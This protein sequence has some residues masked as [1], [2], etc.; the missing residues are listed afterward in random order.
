MDRRALLAWLPALALPGLVG[1]AG[2][3]RLDKARSFKSIDITGNPEFGHDFSLHDHD[4]RPR[5]LSDYRGKVVTL[6]FGYLHC[7][8][9]CPTHLAREAAVL[10]ALG[11][12]DAARVQTL[13]VSV[14][15]ARDTPEKIKAYVTVFHPSFIG[16]TGTEQE[17]AQAARTFK[18]SYSKVPMPDSSLGYAIDH[19]TLTL[20][21]DP[22]GRLRLAVRHEQSATD[23]ATDL[24]R[25]LDGA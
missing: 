15:P 11:P 2:C 3:E 12:Q 13:F 19:S 24:K 22:K 18:A 20:V 10:Q 7:P 21:F 16:L 17:I 14:D 5:S 1:L 6:F 9:F 8:D 23:V 25:L 4:G